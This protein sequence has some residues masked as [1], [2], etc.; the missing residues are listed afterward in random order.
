VA[1][2]L[3]RLGD[4]KMFL[5]ITGTVGKETEMKELT[6]EA[7]REIL[8]I[9][10]DSKAFVID[11]APGYAQELVR[12]ELVSNAAYG[13]IAI[14]WM[15]GCVTIMLWSYI[16]WA[17]LDG[18]TKFLFILAPIMASA[19]AIIPFLASILP[20]F[21]KAWTAPKVLIVEKLMAMVK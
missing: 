18:D 6:I 19:F 5:R 17:K 13:V 15:V 3:L 10:K 14:A 21:L 7:L 16:H 11:Q 1:L 12:Y 4:N 8:E 9:V 20:D 2:V